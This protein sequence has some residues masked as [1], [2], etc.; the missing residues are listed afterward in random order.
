MFVITSIVRVVSL[1]PIPGRERGHGR[2]QSRRLDGVVGAAGAGAILIIAVAVV[3]GVGAAHFVWF[4]PSY[5]AEERRCYEVCGW[6]GYASFEI[7]TYRDV[8]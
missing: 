6:V 4:S 7:V 5:F 1:P 2:C 3:A 8:S